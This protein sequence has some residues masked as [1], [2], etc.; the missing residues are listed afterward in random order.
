MKFPGLQFAWSVAGGTQLHHCMLLD[1]GLAHPEDSAQEML[2]L[3]FE[4]EQ[5]QDRVSI[6]L[7][8]G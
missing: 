3:L 5:P 8:E 4:E 6:C 1:C 2:H 7:V